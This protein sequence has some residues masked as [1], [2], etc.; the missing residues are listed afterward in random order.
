MGILGY[1]IQNRIKTNRESPPLVR[2][3]RAQHLAL[4]LTPRRCPLLFVSCPHF[5]LGLP[6]T[7][8]PGYLL[9]DTSARY[10]SIPSLGCPGAH[11][12]LWRRGGG[13]GE[14]GRGWVSLNSLTGLP[15]SPGTG[16]DSSGLCR[17]LLQVPDPPHP[18]PRAALISWTGLE[19]FPGLPAPKQAHQRESSRK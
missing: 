8:G 9:R 19:A 5:K 17:I 7:R 16:A 14:S 12:T 2:L 6:A 3:S 4:S 15:G 10:H 18:Q 13:W 1:S 11:L